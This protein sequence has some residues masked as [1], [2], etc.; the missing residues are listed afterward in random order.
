MTDV[1]LILLVLGTGAIVA[2]VAAWRSGAR[3]AEETFA[4]GLSHTARREERY[5]EVFDATR[6]RRALDERRAED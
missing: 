5:F 2:V 1:L 4:P 6:L 3:L